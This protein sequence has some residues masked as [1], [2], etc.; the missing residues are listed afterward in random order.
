MFTFLQHREELEVAVSA[1][2]LLRS[3]RSEPASFL[4]LFRSYLIWT[5][6]PWSRGAPED[7]SAQTR[8]HRGAS[9]AWRFAMRVSSP[10]VEQLAG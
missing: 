3:S 6:A 10:R 7:K 2:H 5:R 1:F 8:E 4:L 9:R